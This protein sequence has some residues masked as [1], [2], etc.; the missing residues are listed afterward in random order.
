M[1]K[2]NYKKTAAAVV[3]L[4]I[5]AVAAVIIYIKVTDASRQGGISLEDGSYTPDRFTWSGGSGRVSISCEEITVEK[6]QA[7]AVIVFDSSY[8]STIRAGETSYEGTHTDDTSTFTIPV[9]L[10]EENKIFGTTTR[11]TSAHEIEYIIHP[12]LAAAGTKDSAG[13]ETSALENQNAPE[14]TDTQ[15]KQEFSDTSIEISH[16]P[17]DIAGLTCTDKMALD[18]AEG[19][20]VFYY[21]D[22]YRL[23]N[24]YGSGQYLVVPEGMEVPE[25]LDAQIKVL[26]QPLDKIYLAAT[27]AMALF[28]AADALDDIRFT[29]TKASGWYVAEAAAA[30]ESGRMLF[31]GKYSEPDYELLIKEECN[32]AI[33]STMILHSPKVQEMIESLGIPVFIDRSSY[34]THPLGRTEWIKLYG[35]LVGKESEAKNFFDKQAE[36]ISQLKDFKNTEKTVA[37]FHV[38]TNGTVVVRK[39]DDYI[40]SMIEIAGGRYIF[41]NLTNEESS[42]ASVSLSMEE[43]YASAMD[44]DYLI[45]NGTIDNPLNSVD[46]LLAKNELFAEFKA[47]KEGNVWT[48]GKDMY[49]STDIVGQLINDVHQMLTD[50]STDNMTFLNKAS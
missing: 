42:S 38:D 1:M 10:N 3:L 36:V 20:D 8:Y 50:G 25:G 32:L 12:Y 49:Q 37:F 7:Y 24:V 43:F 40:P 2:K 27:S 22:G 46:D 13:E 23:I 30:M 48:I 26:K 6:G 16:T 4:V 31:A 44:A 29:G 28:R 11:M 45:Y 39:S 34:E 33:E 19:F 41:D 17:P 35:A 9:T 5:L 14:D 21:S 18:Y 47:V 15:E